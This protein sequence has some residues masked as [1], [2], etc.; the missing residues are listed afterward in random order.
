[1]SASRA[2][3]IAL[4]A[5]LLHVRST[6]RAFRFNRLVPGHEVAIG[7]AAAAV[8]RSALF[9]APF[10]HVAL[11]TSRAGHP[12]LG[13]QWLRVAAFGKTAAGHELAELAHLDDH[14]P[15]ALLAVLARGLILELDSLN[16]L[17]CLGESRLE[18]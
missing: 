13:Q 6:A 9:R 2:F 4:F 3:Q 15:A 7:V 11:V 18:R 12:D 16:R 1:M 8:K 14:R 17:L 5:D 10:H